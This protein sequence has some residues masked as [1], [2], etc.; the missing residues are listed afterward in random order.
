MAEAAALELAADDAGDGFPLVMVHGLGGTS[1]V[2]QPQMPELSGYRVYRPDLPGSGRS[3]LP[4]EPLSMELFA[5]SVLAAARKRGIG[6]AHLVGHSLG[7]I[8]CQ[9]MAADAPDFVASLILFGALTE[10]PDAA[11]AGLLDR[12]RTARSDGM[13]GIADQIVAST[14]APP[15]HASKPEAVAFVRELVMRQPPEGYARTCEALSK[16]RAVEAARIAAPTLIITG[17]ADPIAPPSM[18]QILADRLPRAAL[19][20]VNGC[21]H[22]A[23]I[24]KAQESGRRLAEFLRRQQI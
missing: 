7:T 12:A 6:R 1:N 22:W 23:T 18:G 24:E 10:P 4:A 19:S 9:R 17:D 8:V 13:T 21:G 14:L 20:V 3:P 15:A 5:A 16:A 2:F 11:R